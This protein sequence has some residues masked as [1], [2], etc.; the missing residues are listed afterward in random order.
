ML[1][2]KV[3]V[4]PVPGAGLT[5]TVKFVAVTALTQNLVAAPW[6]LAGVSV[7]SPT[8]GVYD[9]PWAT[10]A[11]VAPSAIFTCVKGVDLFSVTKLMLSLTMGK[12]VAVVPIL[13]CCFAAP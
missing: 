7:I 4:F 2:S 8:A 3:A 10:V 12:G 9:R 13:T 6:S 1:Q 11:L 5:V